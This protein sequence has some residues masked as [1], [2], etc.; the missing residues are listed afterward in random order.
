MCD[1]APFF[2]F[3]AGWDLLNHQGAGGA[4]AAAGRLRARLRGGDGAALSWSV[5]CVGLS[6][7][8]RGLTY[9]PGWVQNLGNKQVCT[10]SVKLG[11][12]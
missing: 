6:E 4:A 11:Q 7:L 5:L 3:R 2:C 9:D 12:L 1:A 10:S 8:E